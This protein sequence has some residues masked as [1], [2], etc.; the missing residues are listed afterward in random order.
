[1]PS[2][3]YALNCLH[4]RHCMKVGYIYPTWGLYHSNLVRFNYHKLPCLVGS[5]ATPFSLI[6]QG[7]GE[8]GLVTLGYSLCISQECT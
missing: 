7:L 4:S 6:G 1:M 2:L 8:K 5:Q 3:L